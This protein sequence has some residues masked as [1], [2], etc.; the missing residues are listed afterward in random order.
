MATMCTGLIAGAVTLALPAV[1]P[2][3][4]QAF[5]GVNWIL[6]EEPLDVETELALGFLDYL[7]LVSLPSPEGLRAI[8]THAAP[9]RT[10]VTGERRGAQRVYVCV[11]GH[12]CGCVLAGHQR[13]PSAQGAERQRA[14]RGGAGWWRG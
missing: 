4:T 2:P 6:S 14:G 5:V 8:A 12:V 7:M 9:S 11:C 3:A 1:L 10:I 13:Q